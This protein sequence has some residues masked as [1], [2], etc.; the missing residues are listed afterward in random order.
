M[1]DHAYA[2]WSILDA[3]INHANFKILGYDPPR[4]WYESLYAYLQ[5]HPYTIYVF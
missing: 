5:N 4:R 2:E 1:T 3:L